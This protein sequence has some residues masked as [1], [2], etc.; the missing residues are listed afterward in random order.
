MHPYHVAAY[1][2]LRDHAKPVSQQDAADLREV[3]AP[4]PPSGAH[5]CR[6]KRDRTRYKDN[7][8]PYPKMGPK[9]VAAQ[10]NLDFLKRQLAIL[11][12]TRTIAPAP[13]PDIYVRPRETWFYVPPA[14]SAELYPSPK[15]FSFMS[16]ERALRLARDHVIEMWRL[17]HDVDMVTI[18]D[19]W[20]SFDCFKRE[21]MS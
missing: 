12:G 8:R 6:L 19:L 18:M 17:G 3:R 14:R 13:E 21:A 20:P 5:I 11:G 9:G 10:K 1:R 16:P 2:Y 4:Q 15:P 7:P